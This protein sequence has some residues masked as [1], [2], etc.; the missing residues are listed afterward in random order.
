MKRQ[1]KTNR[2][3]RALMRRSYNRFE[4]ARELSD[5]CLHST[6][7]TI[8]GKGITVHREFETVSGFEGRPTKCCRYWITPDQHAKAVKLLGRD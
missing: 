5:W 6:A 7:A 4:A 2:V 1:T 8:Q 3:I